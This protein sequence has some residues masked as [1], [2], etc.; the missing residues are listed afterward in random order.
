MTHVTFSLWALPLSSKDHWC[1][2]MCL[3]WHLALLSCT[4]YCSFLDLLCCI[5]SDC[6]LAFCCIII[7]FFLAFFSTSRCCLLAFYCC[8]IFSHCCYFPCWYYCPTTFHSL[9]FFESWTP[10]TWDLDL[11]AF[12]ILEVGFSLKPTPVLMRGDIFFPSISSKSFLLP[13]SFWY[14]YNCN[15]YFSKSCLNE[16][17]SFCSLSQ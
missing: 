11:S 4:L 15:F 5:I 7:C 12:N 6:F 17:T 3:L 16:T 10:F 2:F 13:S 1:L 9:L 14:W 8:L